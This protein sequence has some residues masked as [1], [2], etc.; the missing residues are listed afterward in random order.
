M[1]NQEKTSIQRRHNRIRWVVGAIA[2]VAIAIDEGLELRWPGVV[3][4]GLWNVLDVFFLAIIGASAYFCVDRILRLIEERT[5]LNDRLAEA[6]RALSE[7]RQR[8]STVVRISQMFLDASDEDEVIDLAMNLSRELLGAR[9]VAFVPLDENA[10]PMGAKSLGDIPFSEASAWLEYLASPGV[11]E[12]CTSCNDREQVKHSCPLLVNAFQ[13]ATGVYCVPLRRDDQDFG[14]L[15]LFMPPEAGVDADAQD[16]LK[17]IVDESTIALESVRMRQKAMTTL[18]QIQ[19]LR[20]KTDLNNLLKD[21]IEGLRDTL[22]ADYVLVT[23]QE[24]GGS[25][26]RGEVSIGAELPENGRHLVDGILQSVKTSHEPVLLENAAGSMASSAGMRAIVAAP[27]LVQEAGAEDSLLGVILAAS[28]RARAF[29]QRQLSILQMIAGQVS[30]VIQNVRLVAQLEYKT[31]IEERMRL[32]REIHDGL[33]QT[34]GFLKLKTAQMRHY[35][36]LEDDELLRD[37]VDTSYNVLT[38]AYQDA[39][40]AIDGLRI[41]SKDGFGGWLQQTVDEF[42]EY[43]GAVVTVC[44][45]EIA[46]NLPPEV[47]AQLIRIIQEALSNVRKHSGAKRVEITCRQAGGDI[48]LEISDD[49]VG[50]N[51]EDVPGP[52]QHG[53]HGMRERAE[54]IDADL[55]VISQ[56]TQGTVVRLRLPFQEKEGLT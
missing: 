42:Q 41:S 47:N 26:G 29:K 15:N 9:G 34:L 23:L 40:Q 8:Q 39:R 38:E 13:N 2:L 17:T 16:L 32:A 33:A 20:E 52:S 25:P 55:Q 51:V 31:M 56:F 3:G 19:S 7:A 5:L 24:Q 46:A 53:L 48:F 45:P 14:I 4:Q 12:A 11:R 1:K 6:G 37:A 36:E 35:I 50:F 18:R 44:D 30:L 27:L 49:G 43:S 10:Q 54:L 22:E 21:L 28:R